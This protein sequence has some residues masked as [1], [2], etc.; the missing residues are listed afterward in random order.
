ML[1]V[2]LLRYAP[3]VVQNHAL[4]ARVWPTEEVYEDTLRVH[5]HRLAAQAG[6]GRPSPALHPNRAR[7][8]LTVYN[9]PIELAR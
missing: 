3:R 8:R 2:V 7:R 5:M 9:T 6:S 1:M 4:L